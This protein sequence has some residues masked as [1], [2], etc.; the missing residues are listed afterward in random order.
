MT[1]VDGSLMD[2]LGTEGDYFEKDT[3]RSWWQ[4]IRI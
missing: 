2:I 4:R 1:A 3:E